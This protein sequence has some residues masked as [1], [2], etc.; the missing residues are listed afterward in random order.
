[1][2]RAWLIETQVSGA[3]TLYLKEN[4][5]WD[6]DVNKAKKHATEKEALD[7]LAAMPLTHPYVA[8]DTRATE[9][10]WE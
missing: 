9:H 7:F 6:P 10:Q 3:S 2:E 1:M 8:S 5:C 4:Y